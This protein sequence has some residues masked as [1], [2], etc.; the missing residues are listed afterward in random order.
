MFRDESDSVQQKYRAPSSTKD[1][2]PGVDTD[3]QHLLDRTWRDSSTST[4]SSPAPVDLPASMK[5]STDV[6]IR[7]KETQHTSFLSCNPVSTDALANIATAFFLTQYVPGSHFDFLPLMHDPSS[8]ES[9]LSTVIK[10]VALASLSHEIRRPE[11]MAL[12]RRQYSHGLVETNRAL[13]SAELSRQDGTLASILLLAHFEMLAA[14]DT[15][16]NSESASISLDFT[17]ST[18]W[19]RHVDGAVA[20]VALRPRPQS[21]SVVSQRLNGHVNATARYS[22]I[23]RRVRIPEEL[24]ALGPPK[25][26][27]QNHNDPN[28]RFMMAVDD[29]TELRA[30]IH[31]G[32]LTDPVE[33]IEQ[34]QHI[35]G[36]IA[37]VGRSISSSWAFDVITTAP[38]I[39]REG[40]YKNKYH[41][42]SNHH[43]A[44]LWNEL[45]MTRLALHETMYHYAGEVS[46]RDTVSRNNDDDDIAV[47]W[48]LERTRYTRTIERL[49]TDIC[50]STTQ[51][52]QKPAP[53]LA[54]TSSSSPSSSPSPPT[55]TMTVASA[56]FLIW[57][58]F[59]AARA[60]ML[61]DPAIRTFAIDRLRFIERE[62]NIPPARK[63]A[64][65]LERGVVHE[66]WLHMLHLF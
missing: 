21:H 33:I 20:L 3:C 10:A 19:S 42:Y 29:F 56:Y 55:Q 7:G 4:S 24:S 30:Q 65:M 28:Q 37:W 40:V 31:E 8:P 32:S 2:N 11:L 52:L 12:A 50:Q 36:Q 53:V 66:D 47:D 46:H 1:A 64:V 39:E 41:L 34:A 58:L 54:G 63:A 35:D 38:G 15:I 13:Q 14:D 16:F 18:T 25:R 49:A 61:A 57:P 6:V 9:L 27:R 22:C 51:F 45:R 60:S 5:R 26:M 43:T 59:S 23:Q 62:M 44:Q 17:P 48:T